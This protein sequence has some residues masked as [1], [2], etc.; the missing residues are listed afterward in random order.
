MPSIYTV[1]INI[2][3]IHTH[4]CDQHSTNNELLKY[5]LFIYLY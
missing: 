2:P 1:K 3:F 5:H 4:N